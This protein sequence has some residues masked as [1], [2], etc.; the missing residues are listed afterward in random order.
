M[1]SNFLNRYPQLLSV[2]EGSEINTPFLNEVRLRVL[3]QDSWIN[4]LKKLTKAF[5][6][7]VFSRRYQTVGDK[8]G[9]NWSVIIP[10][11]RSKEEL[12]SFCDEADIVVTSVSPSTPIQTESS[13]DASTGF[14]KGTRVL[15]D[16]EGKV[17][18]E[19][20]IIHLPG[21]AGDTSRGN[22]TGDAPRVFLAGEGAGE[23][24][25]HLKEHFIR[26]L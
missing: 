9:F 22:Y 21:L 2:I 5:P 16:K 26:G 13:T 10:G 12:Q 14:F 7:V 15:K 23:E 8:F 17:D 24:I 1:L 4:C 25:K 18:G 20:R 11:P 3:D 19:E 6:N